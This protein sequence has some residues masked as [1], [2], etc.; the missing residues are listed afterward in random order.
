MT[1]ILT[2]NSNFVRHTESMGLSNINKAEKDEYYAKLR[3]IK[4]QKD[5]I[6]SLK[7][8]ISSLKEDVS[9]IKELLKKIANK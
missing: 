9:E 4:N 2:E 3:M 8:E 5:E 7:S 1:M 6:N